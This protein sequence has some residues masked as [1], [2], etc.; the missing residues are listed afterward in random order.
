MGFSKKKIEVLLG[1]RE[2]D[3]RSVDLYVEQKRR[4]EIMHLWG[5]C[6][7]ALRTPEVQPLA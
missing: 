4:S 5:N 6:V 1:T 3:Y 7:G 2:A